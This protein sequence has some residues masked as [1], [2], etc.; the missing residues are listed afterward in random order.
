MNYKLLK[1][2]LIFT[3]FKQSIVQI[4]LILQIFRKI[5]T[6]YWFMCKMIAYCFSK[7]MNY[8]DL[9]SIH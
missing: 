5:K 4:F 9:E 8:Y 7:F 3:M 6:F 1:I 2:F